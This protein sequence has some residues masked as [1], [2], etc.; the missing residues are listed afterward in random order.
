[1]TSEARPSAD[2]KLIRVSA[3]VIRDEGG[4]VLTA[5]KRGTVRF[6]LPGGKPE[7]GETAAETALREAREELG[8]DLDAELLRPLGVFLS[9]AANEPGFALES[10]VFTHPFVVVAGPAAEID[11]LRWLDPAAELPGD[12][13]PM[14]VENV[15]PALA[16]LAERGAHGPG[17][18]SG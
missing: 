14:L 18:R 2:A 6:M 9:A 3:V 7:P 4:R 16:A 11:E 15:L 5:R 13:A 12:L 1:M 17:G 8:V 10:A